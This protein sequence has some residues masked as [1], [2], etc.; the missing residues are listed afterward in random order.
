M[1]THHER[2]VQLVFKRTEAKCLLARDQKERLCALMAGRMVPDEHGASTIR[3]LYLDT[4]SL[5][6][7]C[8][9]AEHPF[10][11][12]KLRIRSYAPAFPEDQVFSGAQEEIGRGGLQETLPACARR[13][14]GALSGKK[15]A[16]GTD[17]ERARL[18]RQARRRRLAGLCACL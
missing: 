18:E 6:F 2:S 16:A 14:A 9:S 4:P 5:I 7:A 13:G 17:R 10:Y 1:E 11:K 3:N 8:R 12:E 15:A